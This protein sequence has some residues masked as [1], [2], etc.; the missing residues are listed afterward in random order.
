MARDIEEFLRRAAERRQQQKGGGA[1]NRQPPD[2]A[3]QQPPPRPTP[4][5]QTPPLVIDDV[6]VVD[7][8][9]RRPVESRIKSKPGLSS[10]IRSGSVSDHVK[11]HIDTSDIAEHASHL[12]ERISG[13][14]DQVESRIHNRLNRDITVIDDKPTITDDA[15]PAIFGAS[16][17]DKAVALRKLLSD[18]KSVGQAIVIAEIL[19]RPN[20]DD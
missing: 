7:S 12:G 13:V 14:H 18:P 10:S 17:A 8:T 1:P 6:E 19:R 4:R 2:A 15:S 16:S 3:P 9:P 11:S 5:R 20:F